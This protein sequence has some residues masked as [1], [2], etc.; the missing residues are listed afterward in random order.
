MTKK[1]RTEK[2]QWPQQQSMHAQEQEQGRRTASTRVCADYEHVVDSQ[3]T[4]HATRKSEREEPHARR[5][6]FQGLAQ[7]VR[8]NNH[9]RKQTLQQ[10][11]VEYK[12]KAHTTTAAG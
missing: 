6:T 1:H 7:A 10:A 12:P 3:L 8:K 9:S 2:R 5:N 4:Q 11:E